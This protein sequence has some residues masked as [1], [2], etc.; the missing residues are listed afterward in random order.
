MKR[1]WFFFLGV[2]L[3]GPLALS[4]GAPWWAV[5]LFTTIWVAT[6]LGC[7][8]WGTRTQVIKQLPLIPCPQTFDPC[9]AL[10][11]WLQVS[12]D[13]LIVLPKKSAD[14][15][16]LLVGPGF[17]RDLGWK[18]QDIVGHSWREFIHPEDV[19]MT[20]QTLRS[21][22]TGLV[23]RVTNRWK[24]RQDQVDKSTRWVWLEWAF[25][26]IETQ[27][28]IYAH[29]RNLTNRFEREAQ[30]ATWAMITSDLM[31]VSDTA[32][33]ILERKFEWA[34]EAWTRHLGWSLLDLYGMPIISLL[35]PMEK[36][37][38][39][40]AREDREQP[41]AGI[42][43]EPYVCKIRGKNGIYQ[44]YEWYAVHLNGK[45]Y[46]VGRDIG[47]DIKQQGKLQSAIADLEARNADL[48]KFA[49]VAAHQLRSPP[50]TI[51][52]I[53]QALKEDYGHLLDAE[54]LQFLNDIQ[55]DA[56]QMAE[57]VEGLHRFSTVRT[58]DDM[59]LT[60][61]NLESLLYDIRVS[62]YRRGIL[63]KTDVLTWN[64]LPTVVGNRV[65]L[66]EVF[67]NLINNAVKFNESSPKKV[68]I[69]ASP[70][71]DGRWD[72]S[73]KDNGIGIDYHYHHKLF[74]MFQRVHPQYKG[75][76]VG[77]AL[78]SAIV[79]RLGGDIRVTSSPG[80]GATFTFDLA[81]GSTLEPGA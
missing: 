41:E 43:E 17:E 24:H 14:G 21:L 8:K 5:A 20:D 34:N 73:V 76:G 49:S 46:S 60:R 45:L 81:D 51:T 58:K 26:A 59:P 54:G 72:I 10:N 36:D 67:V 63:R 9:P 35:E 38:V 40:K 70:R 79:D 44:V 61:V 3:Y 53:A 68:H 78:V 80:Q 52:G 39:I 42:Q 30:M 4:W 23:Q 22:E 27:D 2:V 65:L 6:L 15:T 71:G 13:L 62:K 1:C 28:Y 69:A 16:I 29:A 55:D 32:V 18:Y 25:L 33:P 66:Q 77:L 75:T 11:S 47:A 12:G 37:S 48:E 50:R 57:I 7:L 56:D 74:Q 19:G 64:H 31:A